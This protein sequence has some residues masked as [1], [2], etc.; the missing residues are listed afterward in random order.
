MYLKDDFLNQLS[1]IFDCT[2]GQRNWVQVICNGGVA[3]AASIFY[4]VDVGCREQPIDFAHDF[5]ASVFSIVVLGSLACC[6]GDTWAS[7]IGSVYGSKP[8]LITTFC[9]VPVGTNG[10]VTIIG[11]IASL[12]GG[13]IVG[14][15]YYIT[16]VT[17]VTYDH[18]FERYPAQWPLVLTGLLGG[19]IGSLIDS[20]IGAKFQ[21]SAYCYD[22]K[23]IV[24]EPSR[25]AKHICGQAIFSNHG[26][27]FVSA[28]LTG[29]IMPVI[30]Y[31]VWQYV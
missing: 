23:R 5:T 12:L 17:L 18:A 6:C 4:L 24:H 2:G 15:A 22:K 26:V 30:A 25:T 9:S 3:L 14:I 21:Y 10:G 1:A 11:T 20:L 8:R 19:V 29:L 16:M 13:A 31:I 7:E 28:L 27:N